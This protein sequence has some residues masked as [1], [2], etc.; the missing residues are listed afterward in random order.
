MRKRLLFTALALALLLGTA[1]ITAMA[2]SS[3][4]MALKRGEGNLRGVLQSFFAVVDQA[5]GLAQELNLSAEQKDEIKNILLS[6]K[7][8]AVEFHKQLTEKR[9]E[10]R[11]ELLAQNPNAAKID[12][13]TQ[14]IAGL[15]AQMATFR[16]RRAVEIT[17]VLTPEQKQIAQ[18][19]LKE[20]E[21]LVAD[22]KEEIMSLLMSH[23]R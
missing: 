1:G 11:D 3:H 10:L 4:F 20:L 17:Q 21:P 16:I 6:A 5:R 15:N 9:H 7:P 2:S 19:E 22:L 23:K 18:K 14:E 12:Q 13:L 8:A